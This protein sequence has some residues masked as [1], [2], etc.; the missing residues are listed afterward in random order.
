MGKKHDGFAD[1]L[2][3]AIENCGKTRYQIFKETGI[4]QETL[5]RFVNGERGLSMESI[6]LL[7]ENLGLKISKR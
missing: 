1:Q 4:P 2:R 5:S 3:A 7:F 6:E